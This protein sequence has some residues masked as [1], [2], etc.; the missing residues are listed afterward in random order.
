LDNSAGSTRNCI[1]ELCCDIETPL[2]DGSGLALSAA[3]DVNVCLLVHMRA[4]GDGSAAG[5]G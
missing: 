4:V 5:E 1:A 2:L 3:E